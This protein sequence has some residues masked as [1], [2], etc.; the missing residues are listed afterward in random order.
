MKVKVMEKY[1]QMKI[2]SDFS[3][4]DNRLKT[5]SRVLLE[6]KLSKSKIAL[7]TSAG[8]YRPEQKAF[9]T[10]KKLGD[11]SFRLINKDTDLK[12]LKIAH[13]HY[14]H[15]DGQLD[16]NVLLPLDILRTLEKNQVIGAMAENHYSFSG[17]ILDVK[18]LKESL[19]KD[20]AN[21]LKSEGVDIA[22]L[23]PA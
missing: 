1:L 21:L 13:S 3:F 15:T 17:F 18:A 4:E 22:I 10:E 2:Y 23:S 7:I 16:P 12:S 19:S 14:D 6:K 8:F 11:L 9:D 20:I 5:C